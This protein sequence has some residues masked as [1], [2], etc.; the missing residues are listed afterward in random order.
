MII[1]TP[2]LEALGLLEVQDI[3]E[4]W[5]IAVRSAEDQRAANIALNVKNKG[6]R[7]E[8]EEASDVAVQKAVEEVVKGIRVYMFV[9]ISGSMRTAIDEAKSYLEKFVQAFP[10]DQLHVAVFQTVGR[11]VKIKHASSAGIRQAF[12]N[13]SAG[14]GTAIG[15]GIRA[16][17]HHKPADDEDVLFLFVTDEGAVD[18]QGP[19][20]ASG[21][22]PM[23]FGLIKV[24]RS[25]RTAVQNTASNLG[26]PCFEVD[27]A[28][29]D[30]PYAIPRTIRALVAATPVGVTHGVVRS[31]R[32]TLVQ[33]ILDTPLLSK[34]TWA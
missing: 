10:L 31:T 29:F 32:V 1:S 22:R 17:Q 28:T 3:K 15:Q 7:E 6:T 4:R 23:A 11:E 19:V 26:I 14:G 16:L 9:D 8:L 30:D 33:Q 24:G 25:G 20:N 5:S 21:L 18:F 2:T 27:T 13:Y 12:R 34:P